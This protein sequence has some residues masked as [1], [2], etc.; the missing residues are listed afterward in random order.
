V[1]FFT[2]S[3]QSLHT[4]THSLGFLYC[5]LYIVEKSIIKYLKKLK[6]NPTPSGH[7][8]DSWIAKCPNSQNHFITVTTLKDEWGCGYCRKKG[9]ILD[10]KKWVKEL[11]YLVILDG[12]E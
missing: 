3:K 5:T 8:K 7:N 4:N 10:L 12:F 2:C 1:S 9:T 11:E 6:L